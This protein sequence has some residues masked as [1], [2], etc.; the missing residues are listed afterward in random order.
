MSGFRAEFDSARAGGL[1]M[2]GPDGDGASTWLRLTRP[3][4]GRLG[5]RELWLRLS[6]AGVTTLGTT[7]PMA[8][9]VVPH[10]AVE[11]SETAYREA[12]L[13]LHEADRL[14][15]NFPQPWASPDPVNRIGPTENEMEAMLAGGDPPR[16]RRDVH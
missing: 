1:G 6:P 7:A 12:L 13:A 5:Q 9:P 3:N 15:L 4:E 10:L 11:V 16:P 14:W 2:S 8:T